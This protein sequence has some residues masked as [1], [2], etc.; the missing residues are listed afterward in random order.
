MTPRSLESTLPRSPL[1][2]IRAAW[3]LTAALTIAGLALGVLA[4]QRKATTYTG[5]AKVA[6]GSQSL[7][8]QEI[9]GFE[10]AVE[11]LA[12]DYAR[13][14]STATMTPA[15]QKALK[16][17]AAQ[18]TGVRASPIAGSSV[19]VVET[20]AT[21]AVAAKDSA[22]TVAATLVSVVNAS[23]QSSDPADTLSAYTALTAR[24]VQA[25]T[26]VNAA[27]ATFN[28]ATG[29]D[30]ASATAALASTTAAFNGLEIQ[31]AAL[32]AKYQ[33]LI[34]DGTSENSL[35]TVLGAGVSGDDKRSAEE[36]YGLAG[37]VAGF[38]LA[39]CLATAFDRRRARK[40]RQHIRPSS[41][42]P[43]PS[44]AAKR[45]SM[46]PVEAATPSWSNFDPRP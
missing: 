27:Q 15:I 28:K 23:I 32:G 38:L 16:T 20:S 31:Q 10:V 26:A 11:Q 9:G 6:V 41:P 33:S 24:V 46:T 7:S 4:A 5:E 35:H 18:G 36:R 40:P 19:I 30:I 45:S 3:M 14:V 13:Y 1:L 25:R 29:S 12:S 21:T 42:E 34:T 39:I 37:L 8:A 43:G 2:A 17:R 22:A 44:D